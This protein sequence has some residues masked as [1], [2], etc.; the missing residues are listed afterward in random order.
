MPNISLFSDYYTIEDP[1]NL[2]LE[3]FFQFV[4]DGEWQDPIL[5]LR[6]M[7]TKEAR[8]KLKR[9]LPGVTFAGLFS[10]RKDD[11]LIEHSGFI[12][13][14]VDELE[15]AINT[16]YLLCGGDDPDKYIYACFYSPSGNGLRIIFKIKPEKHRESYYGISAYLMRT[17]GLPTDPQS[18]VPSRSFCVTYDPELY[19]AEHRVPIWTDYPKEK[20][21]AKKDLNFVYD[22][23]DFAFIFKQIKERKLNICEEYQDY[24]KI[25]FA[26]SEKFGDAGRD[27]YHEIC[28]Y[29]EKYNYKKVDK[30]FDYCLRSKNLKVANIATFYWYAKQAGVQVVSERT[31]KIRKAT[32]AGKA[33]GLKV[34]QII[35]NLAKQ[36]IVD[37]KKLVEDIYSSSDIELGDSIVD[38]LELFVASSYNFRRNEITRYIERDGK[39]M[40]QSDMNTVFISAKKVIEKLEYQLLDRL[41]LSDF[42]PTYNPLI[43]FFNGLVGEFEPVPLGNPKSSLDERTKDYESPLIDKLAASIINNCPAY[44]NYFLRKWIVGIVS[45]AYKIHSPLVF[46]LVGANQG[47]GKTEFFRRLLPHELQKYY[48]E[49]KLDAGKD[50]DILMTQKIVIMDDELSGKSKRESSRLKEL[51]SKQWFSLREPYGRNNV[52]ILRIAVLCGTSNFKEILSDTTGNRRIIPI[53]VDDIDKDLYNSIN[54]LELFR[55]AAM[56]LK[57][58]FDWRVITP[59][60]ISYLRQ[61]EVEYEILNKERELLERFYEVPTSEV[62]L[63]VERMTATDIMVEL[64]ILTRQ[65]CSLDQ[66]GKQLAKLGF[67]QRSTSVNKKSVKKWIVKKINR[68]NQQIINPF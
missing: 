57:N 24:L 21:P 58:G 51:T 7:K 48:A 56:L 10:V 31:V 36:D 3:T 4:K 16:K 35:D 15:D 50:D 53:P 66:L 11:A 14:D 44:T 41:L 32:L 45:A 17:Y 26:F 2:P 68:T 62:D 20:K 63:T 5:A 54:K 1:D 49:S 64:E 30:Q 27:Y 60:D 22:E 40:S 39:P 28:S 25:G 9:S 42:I 6:S 29:S 38:H 61:N 8:N 67:V 33:T 34:D 55:E 19:L 37:C 52:D 18:M 47:K 65:R 13:I 59:E 12:C 46:V 43:D 23:S